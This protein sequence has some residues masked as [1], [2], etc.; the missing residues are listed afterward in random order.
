MIPWVWTLIFLIYWL[1]IG[2]VHE[3][4][5]ICL[6]VSRAFWYGE[7]GSGNHIG[8]ARIKRELQ[9][10]KEGRDRDAAL[11]KLTP[12]ERKLLGLD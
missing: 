11:A 12:Y 2:D 1:L 9:E 5:Q 6:S 10:Q 3:T 8:E 7:N 4:R